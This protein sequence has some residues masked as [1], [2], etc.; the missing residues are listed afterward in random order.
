MKIS[1]KLEVSESNGH[2]TF[3]LDDLGVTE[4]EWNEMS[5]SEKHDAVE[6]AVFDLPEQP[7]WMVGSFDER[8][9]ALA[10]NVFGLGEGGVQKVPK[11]KFSTKANRKYKCSAQY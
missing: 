5:E 10:T 9:V 6:K 3:D 2:H 11:F 8:Q 4:Q 1:V 7:Y